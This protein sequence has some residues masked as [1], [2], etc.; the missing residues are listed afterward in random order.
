M[1]SWCQYTTD[2]HKYTTKWLSK[3]ILRIVCKYILT[4]HSS[5]FTAEGR[6]RERE[7]TNYTVACP[8]CRN[9]LLV[10]CQPVCEVPAI[11]FIAGLLPNVTLITGLHTRHSCLFA[12]CNVTLYFALIWTCQSSGFTKCHL[13]CAGNRLEFIPTHV[14]VWSVKSYCADW[15]RETSDLFCVCSQTLWASGRRSLASCL[16]SR[17]QPPTHCTPNNGFLWWVHAKRNLIF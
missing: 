3:Q 15:S 9:T 16:W 14:T 12:H 8:A 2:N 11:R 6:H 10:S 5:A 4:H 1:F 17:P 7:K 13:K